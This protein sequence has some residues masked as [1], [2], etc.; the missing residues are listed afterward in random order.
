MKAIPRLALSAACVMAFTAPAAAQAPGV[1]LK[2]NPRV[3]LYV[4]LTDL[5]D[6][7]GTL[8]TVVSEQSGNLAFGL[9]AELNLGVLPVGLRAN[10]DYA[11]GS[12]VTPEGIG[13]SVQ[14]NVFMLAG[15]VIFRPMPTLI[16]IQPYLFAGGGVRQYNFDTDDIAALEDASDPMVHLGGGLDVTFGPLALNAELGDYISWFEIRE[17]ADS[18]V[19]HDLFVTV[20]IVLELL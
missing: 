12:E 6:A 15:D 4:P 8:G 2:L 5:G 16:L 7:G 13:E 10:I 3:G 18:E 20:G 9:G 19:Q 1:D 14:R 17:G 11:T